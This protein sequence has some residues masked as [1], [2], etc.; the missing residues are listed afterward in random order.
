MTEA[1]LHAAVLAQGVRLEK[2][3]RVINN[4]RR[5]VEELESGVSDRSD[6]DATFRLPPTCA[7]CGG[8]KGQGRASRIICLPC[9]RARNA[10]I[11]TKGGDRTPYLRDTCHACGMSTPL[12]THLLCT[13][14]S[15]RL[16]DSR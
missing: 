7:L 16:K 3:A 14:C 15:K 13:T 8:D 2:M 5:R 6:T 4:L 1:E 9:G 11:N 10:A 12:N